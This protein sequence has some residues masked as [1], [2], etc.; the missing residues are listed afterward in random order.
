MSERL[1]KARE[2]VLQEKLLSFRDKVKVMTKDKEELGWFVGKIISIGATFRLRDLKDNDLMTVHEKVISVRSTYKFFKGGETDDSK[3]IGS[4][5][6]KIVSITPNFWFEDP[7]ENKMFTIKGNIFK[8][9]Y[10]IQK[11]DKDI[12]KIDKKLFK[13]KDTFGIRINPDVDDYTTMIILGI[14]IMLQHEHEERERRR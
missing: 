1:L 8:L 11:D 10:T 12:A 14:V 3:L 9:N 13:I 5:K 4:L 2:F 6:Q 7:N